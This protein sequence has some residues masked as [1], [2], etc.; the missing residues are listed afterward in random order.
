MLRES[1]INKQRKENLFKIPKKKKKSMLLSVLSQI[2]TSSWLGKYGLR[3]D[4]EKVPNIKRSRS[5]IPRQ[6][7]NKKIKTFFN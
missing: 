3:G 7:K 1:M 4:S 6:A 2:Y 5:M